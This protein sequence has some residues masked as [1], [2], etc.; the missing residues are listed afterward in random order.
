MPKV[1]NPYVPDQHKVSELA[2]KPE[3]GL[4]DM[5]RS[6]HWLYGMEG[7]RDGLAVKHLDNPRFITELVEYAQ[8]NIVR[9]ERMLRN[10]ELISKV[11]EWL[12]EGRVEIFERHALWVA[13]T[14]PGLTDVDSAIEHA[15]EVATH[16]HNNRRYAQ[17]LRKGVWET[18]LREGSRDVLLFGEQGLWEKHVEFD[19]F[20]ETLLTAKRWVAMGIE[21]STS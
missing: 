12:Q 5:P 8:A 16:K 13:E 19:S 17:V 9:A 21:P 1:D 11:A 20:D 10:L 6:F 14:L 2:N 4:H 15:R 7:C 3:P 18:L